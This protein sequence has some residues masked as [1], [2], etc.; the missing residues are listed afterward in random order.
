MRSS[1]NRADNNIED[2]H[3]A[4]R[5]RITSYSKRQRSTEEDISNKRDRRISPKSSSS[6]FLSLGNS[7]KMALSADFIESLVA[8]M[9]DVRVTEVMGKQYEESTNRILNEMKGRVEK[10][11]EKDAEQDKEIENIKQRMEEYDQKEKETHMIITGLQDR[12]NKEEVT[13]TL[14]EYLQCDLKAED[15]QYVLKLTKKNE[16]Q[17]NRIRVVFKSKEKKVEVMKRRIKLKG[18][19]VWLADELTPGKMRLAYQA[20]HAMKNK[21]IEA[22]WV[23]NGKVFIKKSLTDRPQIVQTPE[24]I[25]Q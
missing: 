15:I 24:Q 19:E 1:E 7:G 2:K 6:T 3:N 8:A 21:K 12:L 4:V 5:G 10:I 14:N 11:E 13:A 25:P 23:F 9:T 20:R 16:Q 22:T 18:K 17:P